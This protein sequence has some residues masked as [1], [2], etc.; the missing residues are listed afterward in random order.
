MKT[1]EIDITPWLGEEG[2]TSSLWFGYSG[3]PSYEETLPYSMLI[4]QTLESYTVRGVI[5][6]KDYEPA[7]GFIRALE[8]AA[9]YARTKLEEMSE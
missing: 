2:I 7:A 5:G 1:V 6:E 9:A 8:A 3:E 4:D